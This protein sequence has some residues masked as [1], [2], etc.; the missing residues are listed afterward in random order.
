MNNLGLYSPN[1]IVLEVNNRTMQNLS[2][3]EF[4]RTER[5]T[6]EE[7]RVRAGAKGDYTFVQN[8]DRTGLIIAVFKQNAPEN[9]F[10]QSLKEAGT[11]FSVNISRRS[12]GAAGDNLEE[13]VKATNALIG[14]APRKTFSQEES[15]REWSIV[16]GELV[17]TDKAV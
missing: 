6:E 11:I 12:V 4:L 7:F 16:C 3:D 14:V 10:L 1:Q 15:D 2:L 8:L 13:I 9:S 5:T 17:E